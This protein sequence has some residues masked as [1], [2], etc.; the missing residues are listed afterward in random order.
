MHTV[1]QQQRLSR[2]A[3]WRGL[4]ICERTSSELG[5]TLTPVRRGNPPTTISIAAIERRAASVN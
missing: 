1:R 2:V 4:R 3:G 5:T